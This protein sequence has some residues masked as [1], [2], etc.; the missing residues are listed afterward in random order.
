MQQIKI[1]I[2]VPMEIFSELIKKKKKNILK[3]YLLNWMK[4]LKYKFITFK[5][6]KMLS[7]IGNYKLFNKQRKC[8]KLYNNQNTLRRKSICLKKN[9]RKENYKE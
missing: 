7:K 3:E 4:I 5:K 2:Q 9:K 6:D 1:M 8:K